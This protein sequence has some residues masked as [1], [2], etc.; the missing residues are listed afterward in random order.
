MILNAF[1][2]SFLAYPGALLIAGGTAIILY[3]LCRTSIKLLKDQKFPWSGLFIDTVPKVPVTPPWWLW[4]L[5]VAVFFIGVAASLPT[6]YHESGGPKHYVVLLE[7]GVESR[8]RE[9]ESTERINLFKEA[10]SKL[11]DKSPVTDRFLLVRAGFEAQIVGTWMNPKK[12]Q[13]TLK[14]LIPGDAPTNWK[15]AFDAT[16][17]LLDKENNILV[18]AAGQPK[19][20]YESW[21]KRSHY[22]RQNCM[23]IKKG[24]A[25]PNAGIE[26]IRVF[27]SPFTEETDEIEIFVRLRGFRERL[28]R[29]VVVSLNNKELSAVELKIDEALPTILPIRSLPESGILEVKLEP[30]DNQP[31]DDIAHAVIPSPRPIDIAVLSS[32]PNALEILAR[33]PMARVRQVSLNDLK[34]GPLPDIIVANGRDVSPDELP[35]VNTL[36]F[37]GAG[38]PIMVR[39]RKINVNHPLSKDLSNLDIN[40]LEAWPSETSG[41]EIAV[42]A[43]QITSTGDTTGQLQPLVY[44]QTVD[45]CRRVFFTFD[46]FSFIDYKKYR[47]IPVLLV[48]AMEWLSS[49]L[50]LPAAVAAGTEFP[51]QGISQGGIEVLRMLEDGK[52]ATAYELDAKATHIAAGNLEH[53]GVYIMSSNEMELHRF[54]VNAVARPI[55][56][57]KGPET[58]SM[59]SEKS[60]DFRQQNAAYRDFPW[61]LAGLFFLCLETIIYMKSS[62]M[63]REL[64]EAVTFKRASLQRLEQSM[65]SD[66]INEAHIARKKA[67]GSFE[68]NN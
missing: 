30:F 4:V 9:Q 67:F 37:A 31:V 59:A 22:P 18:I 23:L 25:E 64:W 27:S 2:F 51:L 52:Y 54:A 49:S 13:D 28:D 34:E 24:H 7:A 47:T 40:R 43:S 21:L 56:S 66:A 1:K 10:L 15:A 35:L 8:S 6:Q 33:L 53:A 68:E 57:E 50:S 5:L 41:A 60:G 46:P 63:A 58:L 29:K 55:V 65:I 32:S 12:F 17:Q 48:N 14:I 11:A 26:S 3:W 39:P 44:T 42:F 45:R 61:W 38:S 20:E 62:G 36:I 16:E 19:K